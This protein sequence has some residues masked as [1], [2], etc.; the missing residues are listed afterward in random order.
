MT[1]SLTCYT[2]QNELC[3]VCHYALRFQRSGNLN[4]P[5]ISG[6]AESLS[7]NTKSK[8]LQNDKLTETNEYKNT[9]ITQNGY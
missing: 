6:T 8:P 1:F 7:I 5:S 3:M 9:V 2:V 4:F